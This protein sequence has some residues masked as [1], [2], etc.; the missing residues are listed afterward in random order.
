MLSAK[1]A[2]AADKILVLPDNLQ[3]ESTNYYIYPDASVMFAT[4]T[5]N[6]LKK[7]N[8]VETVSMSEVRNAFR[9]N[10]R[11]KLVSKSTLKEFKYKYNVDFVD[12]KTITSKFDTD[13]V[14]VITSS[15]DVQNYLFKQTVWDMLN[16]PGEPVI[17]PTY[18]V[19]TY[20]ALVD[21]T[22]EEILW[23]KNFRKELSANNFIILP[24]NF[25]PANEQLD[26]I[27][28][29]SMNYL[30]A[31]IAGN[32]E[33]IL[34]PEPTEQVEGTIVS[35]IETPQKFIEPIRVKTPFPSSTFAPKIDTMINDL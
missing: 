4:D 34:A 2:F 3:F 32:I 6:Q 15:T 7:H 16:I 18:M 27:K 5:I 31:E 10:I 14:L 22:K 8:K 28:R 9:N 21:V 33:A 20:A 29:Y 23:E 19:N 26:R 24:V 17:K 25:A 13:K 12:L 35:P 11:L 1:S 30:S